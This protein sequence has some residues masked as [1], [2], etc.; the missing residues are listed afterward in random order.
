MTFYS[1]PRTVLLKWGITL[2][3]ATRSRRGRCLLAL[4]CV[5]K[6]VHLLADEDRQVASGETEDHLKHPDRD[7]HGAVAGER[8]LRHNVGLEAHKGNRNRDLQVA[9]ELTDRRPTPLRDY[10]EQLASHSKG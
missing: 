7:T 6:D 4:G 8:L 1:T 5:N 2:P 10:L 9:A 3:P